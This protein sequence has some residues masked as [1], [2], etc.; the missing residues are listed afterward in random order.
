[1]ST[2]IAD[3]FLTPD[4]VKFTELVKKSSGDKTL[5]LINNKVV[6]GNT[7]TNV[8]SF[9]N[10]EDVKGELE[11]ARTSLLLK[12]ND[13]YD[14][15][16]TSDEPVLYKG[17]YQSIVGQVE[18]IDR[19]IDEIDAYV[20]NVNEQKVTMP[21]MEFQAKLQN[22]KNMVHQLATATEGDVYI[23]KKNVQKLV[24]LH[25]EGNQ[26]ETNLKDAENAIEF[27]YIIWDN[28]NEVTKVLTK[29]NVVR[30]PSTSSKRL[31]VAKKAIIKKATKE[32]M[33]KKLT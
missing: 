11:S 3:R 27:D 1:M 15:I 23:S 14:K 31:S 20:N 12:G 25:K 26:L 10:I 33:L 17:K 16:V 24:A 4:Y 29:N 9:K 2:T 21:I 28:K 32:V 8:P 30:V 18:Q 19:M 7:K 5:K 13:L 22:N 6:Y